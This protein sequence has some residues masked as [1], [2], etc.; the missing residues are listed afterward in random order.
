VPKSG[1]ARLMAFEWPV[2]RRWANNGPGW[3]LIRR[4]SHGGF[5]RAS[6]RI[7]KGSGLLKGRHPVEMSLSVL[8]YYFEPF[9]EEGKVTGEE[10]H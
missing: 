4:C 10:V 1:I 5:G 2:L 8:R 7:A 3:F 6:I 9:L